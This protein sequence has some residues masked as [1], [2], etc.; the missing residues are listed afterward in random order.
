MEACRSRST[1][2]GDFGLFQGL[3]VACVLA[4]LA[5]P[6]AA[7]EEPDQEAAIHIARLR[8]DGGGD[9]YSN[10]SSMPNW[11]RAF[12]ERTGIVTFHDEVVV[13]PD[14]DALYRYPIAYMNGHGTVKFTEDEA[15]H[16]REWMRNGGFL[17]AEDNY[18]MDKSF[19]Q[20]VK[21]IFPEQQLV[22]LPNT[23]PIYHSFYN[24]AGLPKIHEHD[25]LPAQSLVIIENGRIELLYTYQCDIGDGIEDPDVHKDPPEIRE[26]AMKMAV[27][28]M[29]YALTH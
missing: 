9:W 24:L 28:I 2:G 13:R 22:E 5:A 27:N 6:V 15:K 12:Q 14:D 25:G 7:T 4:L 8:Y 11:M 18:G 26:L 10:P 29:M 16:L 1:P 3:A 19:R 21:K 23:H 20:E 17:W